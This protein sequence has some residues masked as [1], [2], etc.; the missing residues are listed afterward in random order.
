[1]RVRTFG[2]AG[3]VSGALLMAL[4]AGPAS[5]DPIPGLVY[6]TRSATVAP[7]EAFTS[8]AVN[9]PG[10]GRP[11]S[12]GITADR[13]LRKRGIS[14]NYP[15]S[16]Y[17]GGSWSATLSNFGSRSFVETVTATCATNAVAGGVTFERASNTAAPSFAQTTQVSNCPSG[18]KLI[19]GGGGANGGGGDPVGIVG[20]RPIDGPDSNTKPDDAW[21]NRM[22]SYSPLPGFLAADAI[23]APQAQ[24]HV[25]RSYVKVQ[26]R[27]NAFGTVKLKAP[28]RRH[29]KAIGG[30]A[31]SNAAYDESKLGTSIAAPDRKSWL[32]KLTNA[33][34]RRLTVKAYAI[35]VR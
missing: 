14:G 26:R 5:A 1:M 19:G 6:K 21:E 32:V 4:F 7:G 8:R 22:D 20:M 9:C 12:G 16:P 33:S 29:W 30:G 27:V 2:V 28:C 15:L 11:I 18:T 25:H 35:C 10:S 23:C 31:V 24:I 13:A 34:G 17:A 3:I